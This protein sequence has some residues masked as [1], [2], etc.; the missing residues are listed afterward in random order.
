MQSS[1]S[2][3]QAGLAGVAKTPADVR[4]SRSSNANRAWRRFRANRLAPAALVVAMLLA[5]LAIGAPLISEFVTDVGPNKQSLINRFQP[6]SGE[7]WL[8]TDEYGRDVLT[9]LIYGLRVSLGVAALAT[10]VTLFVGTVVGAAAAFYGGVIDQILMRLVD[11]LMSIPGINLLILLGALFVIGPVEMAIMIALIGWTSLAR[12]IR[13]EVLSIRKRE[14]IEA[15]RVLGVSNRRI[16]VRHVLPNIT[17]IIVVVAI[18]AIPSYVL[19]EAAM[20][21]I[22]LGIQAPTPSLGNMLNGSTTYLYKRPELIV[23]PGL[24]ITLFALVVSIVGN[25]LRDA[26]DPR[27][28]S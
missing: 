22:G 5:A 19:A 11:I 23:Y 7:H 12:V 13:A 1:P 10:A 27:L 17:H 2:T 24:V 4:R 15:A 16:I 3:Q 25:A 20:S 6:A 9:R 8:G 18:G 14:Y 28:N 21:F 26:L